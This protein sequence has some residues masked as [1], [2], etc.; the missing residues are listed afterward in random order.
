MS[1]ETISANK[2]IAKNT[3]FLYIRMLLVMGTSIFTSRVILETLGVEDYGIYNAVGGIVAIISLINGALSS[4]T[5]R[6]LTYELGRNDTEMLSKTFSVSLN[7]HILAA[8]FIVTI[9]ETIGLWF[10]NEKMVIPADRM[11]AAV[12]VYQFSIINIIFNFTQVPYNA[13][14]IAHEN[15]SVYAYVGLYDVF[16]KLII[17]CLIVISPI[18]KLVFYALLLMLNTIIIQVF[19]RF[20]T[21]QRYH[22]C[23]FRL[24]KDKDL[25]S[26]QLSYSGWE[27]F[28]NLA[29]ICQGQG[30]NILLNLFFGPMINAARAI[31]YQI[32]NAV[33]Q[34]ISNFLVATK[35]QIIKSYAEKNY[36]RMYAL[37]FTS[38]R[39]SFFLMLAIVLPVAFE[40]KFIL[41]LWLGDN[42]PPNTYIFTIIILLLELI[43]VFRISLN[44]AF[45][46]IGKVKLG[47]SINGTIMILTLPISYFILNI[48]APSYSVFIVL[49]CINLIV[50]CNAFLIVRSYVYFSL[51]Q[52]LETTLRPCILIGLITTIIP[53]LLVNAMDDGW[54]RFIILTVLTEAT[55]F[56]FIYRLGITKGE[57]KKIV[58]WVKIRF[59]IK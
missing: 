53:F 51:R 23:R 24:I 38:A 11:N 46:A 13:T 7:L 39:F 54:M 17:A 27:I 41:N 28:G 35:P 56:F 48:G 34:F 32:Q 43:E 33:S 59:S 20:Y 58:E 12:W 37:T 16:S 49:T 52:F 1:N 4:S 44:S 30:L 55:L 45:H 8:L 22:E 42:T 25:Y 29:W 21:Y 10:F 6:Y 47:N 5:S 9:A 18:D 26:R 15:M 14:L 31:T 57:R 36:E 3:L 40:L 2:R 19:Y 50:T